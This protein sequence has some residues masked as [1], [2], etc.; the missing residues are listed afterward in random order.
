MDTSENK[1]VESLEKLSDVISRKSQNTFILSSNKSKFTKTVNPVIN[2]DS[3]R[4]YKVAV[5]SFSVYNAI[6]NV[7]ENK[8][9]T[10][11]YSKDKGATYQNIVVY[12]G[13]YNA[14]EII[15]EIYK[16]AD[17]TSSESTMQFTPDIKTNTIVMVLGENYKV[18]FS[19]AHNLHKIFGFRE[20]V[21]SQGTHRSPVRPE[22]IDFHMILIK[23][24]LIS[25]GYV[26]S[27]DSDVMKQNNVIFSLPT[28]TVPTG[29]R[30]IERPQ[31]LTWLPV[32]QQS[33][34]R[35]QIEII[36]ENGNPIDFGSEEISLTI[37]IRQI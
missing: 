30:I 16:Q 31:T 28:F 19:V 37:L 4:S 15:D 36:D 34:Q 3:N 6:R 32:V 12:P 21:Y 23:T 27:T 7:R 33:I 5:Q 2:L 8:N 29:A 14:Q 24:N 25:G 13:S 1:V 26:S 17:I 18:D 9:D 10:F 20:Q 22:I 35:I 11:R